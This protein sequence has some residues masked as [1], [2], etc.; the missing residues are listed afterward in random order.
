MSLASTSSAPGKRNPSL[1]SRASATG[2]VVIGTEP[3]IRG[4]RL[5]LT[6]GGGGAGSPASRPDRCS[7]RPLRKLRYL[8]RVELVREP[9]GHQSDVGHDVAVGDDAD[10]DAAVVAHD[11]DVQT[12]AVR[13]HR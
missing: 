12:E 7:R 4:R 2:S 3:A 1:M 5:R 8:E 10:V 11:R 6:A 9:A 13:D